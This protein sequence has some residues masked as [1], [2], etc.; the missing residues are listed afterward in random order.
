[1]VKTNIRSTTAHLQLGDHHHQTG[2]ALIYMV[3]AMLTL[4][5]LDAFAKLLSDYQSPGQIVFYRFFLQTLFLFPIVFYRGEL[6][7]AFT[8][9]PFIQ[10]MR[11]LLMVLATTFFFAALKYMPLAESISIFFVEPMILTILS[12]VILGEVIRIRRILAILVGF[13]GA[14]IVIKPSFAIFGWAAIFPLRAASCFALYVVFTRQISGRISPLPMQFSVGIM[15]LLVASTMLYLGYQFDINAIMPKTP[16]KAEFWLIIGLGVF[17]TIGH[18]FLT[19]AVRYA[20]TSLLAPFQYLEIIS[21]ILLGYLIFEDIPDRQTI[22][23]LIIIITSGVYL[24][25]RE[26]IARLANTATKT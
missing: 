26:R 20:D 7:S 16:Q 25:H 9:S 2:K 14:L 19:S 6:I 24:M 17:A 13:I 3:T 4:P 12:A 21:A 18:V 23:G 15:A 10:F 5:A 22:F 1:M 8:I 11:G